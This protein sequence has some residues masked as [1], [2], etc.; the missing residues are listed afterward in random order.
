MTNKPNRPGPF[1]QP[2]KYEPKIGLKKQPGQKSMFDGRVRPPTQ[3]EFQEKVQQIE[4]RKA[5]YK[6]RAADLFM[7]FSKSMSDKTLPVNRSPLN[8]DAER[9]ML[10]DMVQLAI[11]IN[12]D[13]NEQ[14]GMG[15]LTWITCLFKTAMAQRDRINELEYTIAALNK[16]LNGPEFVEFINKEITKA[17][18]KKKSGE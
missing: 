1:S 18:D 10:Q 17:L 6:Q 14:E 7:A 4:D 13:P 9:E 11:D 8:R 12:T 15:S 5:S 16:K 3:Q 2:D